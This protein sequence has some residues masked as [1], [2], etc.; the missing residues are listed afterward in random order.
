MK[1]RGEAGVCVFQYSPDRPA[2]PHRVRMEGTAMR[3]TEAIFVSVS[4]ATEASIAKEVCY[5][6]Y[7][8]SHFV[9]GYILKGSHIIRSSIIVHHIV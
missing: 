6:C 9:L 2:I 5:I 1:E 8:C 7:L 4:M 3:E